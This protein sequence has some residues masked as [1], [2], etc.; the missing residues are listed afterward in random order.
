MAEQ[1]WTHPDRATEH[2]LDRPG[3]WGDEPDKVQWVDEDTDLDCLAV[4]NYAGNWCGYVGLPPG[5]PAL[6]LGERLYDLSVHGGVTYGPEP[7]DEEAPEGHGI[8]HVP[9]PGR[10]ADVAWVGFDCGHAW[11]IRPGDLKWCAPFDRAVY[12]DLA[13]VKAETVRLARQLAEVDA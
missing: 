10:P 13:Y 7:C 9:L 1:T 6:D 11:D 5:H 3:P 12:R 8:C 2:G 4:R